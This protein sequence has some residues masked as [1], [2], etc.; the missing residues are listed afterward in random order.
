MRTIA[1]RRRDREGALRWEAERI[2]EG[3]TLD[4]VLGA[5]ARR[6]ATWLRP[7]LQLASGA[8]GTGWYRLG[9]PDEQRHLRLIW[10]PRGREDMFTCFTGWIS[11][12]PEGADSTLIRLAGTVTGP[13]GVASKRA[14]TTLLDL[15]ADAVRAQRTPVD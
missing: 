10:R 12:D 5:L 13:T 4:A 15:L 2:I 9:A 14:L 3:A 8:S 1:I 7:F 11:V 6:P